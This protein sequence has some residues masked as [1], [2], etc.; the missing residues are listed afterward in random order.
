VRE[1]SDLKVEEEEE[2]EEAE[3]CYSADR[4]SLWNEKKR[5]KKVTVNGEEKKKKKKWTMQY[6]LD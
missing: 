5:K 2:L 1:K 6:P 3:D 4:L